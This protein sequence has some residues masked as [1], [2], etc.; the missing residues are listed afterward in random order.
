MSVLRGLP[1]TRDPESSCGTQRRE[2]VKRSGPGGAVEVAGKRSLCVAVIPATRA[3][4]RDLGGWGAQSLEF[5]QRSREG[6][7][8]RGL[9]LGPSASP[10]C[11]HRRLAGG[12][13]RDPGEQKRL[14]CEGVGL[15]R[16]SCFRTRGKSNNDPASGVFCNETWQSCENLY[17]L[18][19]GW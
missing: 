2:D 4:L 16:T 1:R 15:E 19:F 14:G 3:A 12:L 10:S 6:L 7:S 18:H 8:A 17:F 11:G 13:G 9:L 5:H